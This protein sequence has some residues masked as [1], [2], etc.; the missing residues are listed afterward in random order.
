MIGD[1]DWEENFWYDDQIGKYNYN[2]GEVSDDVDGEFR[3]FAQLVWDETTEVGCGK[4]RFTDEDLGEEVEFG[5]KVAPDEREVRFTWS[6]DLC[7]DLVLEVILD[8]LGLFNLLRFDIGTRL[9][10]LSSKDIEL[11]GATTPFDLV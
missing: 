2:T 7:R 10:P 1:A 5:D 11:L 3:G 9:P 6:C 4:V 8:L